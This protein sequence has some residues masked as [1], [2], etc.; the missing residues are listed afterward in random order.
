MF[1]STTQSV[2]Y[3]TMPPKKGKKPDKGPKG[4]IIRIIYC[5]PIV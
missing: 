3:F 2:P 4:R 1:F 5:R